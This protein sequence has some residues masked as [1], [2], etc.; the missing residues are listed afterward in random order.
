MRSPE[1]YYGRAEEA[2]TIANQMRSMM[3]RQDLLQ[4]AVEYEMLAELARD[5]IRGRN[6]VKNQ[7]AAEAR[8]ARNIKRLGAIDE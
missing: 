4:R 5:Q 2:R 8:L 7:T 6:I 3:C 1:Y